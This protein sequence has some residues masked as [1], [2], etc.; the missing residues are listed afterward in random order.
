MR[1]LTFSIERK[2]VVSELAQKLLQNLYS[3]TFAG[4]DPR[5][6]FAR[7]DVDPLTHAFEKK[8]VIHAG[9]GGQVLAKEVYGPVMDELLSQPRQ[10]P[11]AVY[12]H[13]P[14]CE[15]HCLYCG[16]YSR[17]FRQ[18]D[19]QIFTDALLR[20]IEL[21]RDRPAVGSGPIHAVYLGG[22]TPTALAAKDIQ[23]LLKAIH[24]GFP[25]ANDCEVTVEGRIH[26]FGPEKLD[27]C[28]EGGANRFSI[29]VQTFQ[30][31]LRRSMNRLSDQQTVLD[32]LFRLK[33]CDRAVVVID[34]IYGFPRQSMD[35]WIKDIELF[36]SL[37][38]DG[39]DLYQLNVFKKGPLD[40]AVADG[41]LPPTADLPRQALMFAEAVG[42]LEKSR[43]RRLSMS[44]WGRST[45]ER[46]IYNHMMKGAASCLAF[47]PGAGGSLGG[48][49]YFVEND[50]IRWLE[51][52]KKGE[53]PVS[54]L[55]APHR[56]HR[57]YKALAAG[58]DLGGVDLARLDN[59]F[60]QPITAMAEPLLRQWHRCR[61]IDVRDGW[62]ELTL[63]GQFWHANLAQLMIDYLHFNLERKID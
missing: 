52:V 49:A 38:I 12:I 33:R 29:G 9:V 56:F 42:C 51:T 3:P 30:T 20:E 14:F 39:A 55:A 15:S 4:E 40:Q 46:N 22:G 10:G 59:E 60:N 31:E 17:P 5:A 58:F 47:G 63:A 23:R 7:E 54:M 11:S 50:Y 6:F 2:I 43:C 32:T 35:L 24:A 45:R 16:F 57:L 36:L 19:S 53:K 37:E 18:T 21:W 41:K 26:N 8:M 25:L 13:V 1:P 27:A 61:L 28:L 48:H 62:L 44:H 34:L